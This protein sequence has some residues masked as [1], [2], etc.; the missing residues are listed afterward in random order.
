MLLLLLHVVLI[1]LILLILLPG[2]I[3]YEGI[4]FYTYAK[5]KEWLPHERDGSQHLH[6][7]L[8]AGG[9]GS[10]GGSSGCGAA[11]AAAAAAATTVMVAAVVV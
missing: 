1:L 6:W 3:P 5:L 10:F 9:F 7:K 11:A 2:A 8:F 4:K